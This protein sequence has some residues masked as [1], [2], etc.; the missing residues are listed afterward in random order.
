M[1]TGDSYN[2]F[3]E[4]TIDLDPNSSTTF[5]YNPHVLLPY[6][7]QKQRLPIFNVRNHILYLLEKYQVLVLVGETGC[8]KSTQLPQY[9][10]EAG[11]TEE[12]QI[13]GVTEPRRIAATTLA[14]RVSEERG[15]PLGQLVGYTIRFDD[16]SKVGETKIKFMTEGILIRE[17]MSDPLLKNYSVIIL[18]EVHE[19]TL[20]TDII[21][22][23]MKKILRK[24][25]SL[26]LI[27]SSATV[28]ADELQ[29]FFNFNKTKNK[30]NDTSVILSVPGSSY[31]VDIFYLEEPIPD[32]VQGVVDTVLKIHDREFRG[33]IL[34]FLTGQEEIERA[35]CLHVL[36]MHG[37]LPYGDQ[38]KVFRPAKQYQ[39]KVIISTNIAETSVTIPGIVY[40]I[41]SGFV[42]IRWFKPE[43]GIDSLSI[44]PISQASANQRAGRAGRN[45]RGKAYRLYRESDF[46]KLTKA[47]PCEMQRTD[48]SQAILQLKALYIHNVLRF[49]FPSPPPAKN[50]TVALQLLFALNA[51][52][53]NG[54]LTDP[55]GVKMAEIP[56]HPFY[57]KML[58]ASDQFHCSKEI[59]T[60]LSC[61]QVETIFVKPNSGSAS[62]RARIEHRKFQATEGDLITLLNAYE[63]FEENGKSRDWCMKYFLN[64]KGL[65][66]VA[67]I[68]NQVTKLLG[69]DF[70]F[71][72]AAEDDVL[73]RKAITS[74]LFQNAAYLHYSGVYKS[75]RGDQELS[76]HPSSV[77][78]TLEQPSWVL[79]C[80][81]VHTNKAYM[82][83]IT[84]IEPEWLEE[85][86][87]HYY[88]KKVDRDY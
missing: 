81:V 79:Y 50:L 70:K 14:A 19:R 5:V 67:E 72:S 54:E 35:M 61:I 3:Q 69:K 41:D 38:L 68:Q 56:I 9:L 18:D 47:T 22:G 87:P 16:C 45:C 4:D 42:K 2:S 78:Y 17:I 83:N 23:L 10:Y 21:M 85:L 44:V 82:K 26:R 30:E 40:V 86:A 60:I 28:D 62:I 76:I 71:E 13:I 66:R 33:D 51:I 88:E 84:V 64:Y 52:D 75:V 63:A 53:E 39:R 59:L 77:L 80:D 20:F 48:L 25:K 7:E 49:D 32:Y 73:V 58:L 74:G 43:T 12:G 27:V 57:S 24:N 31:S 46:E 65:L 55:L 37:S 36:P 11:W 6:E 29:F 8:G 15:C 1:H 34:A